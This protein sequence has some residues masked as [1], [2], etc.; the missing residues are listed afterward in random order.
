MRR[1]ALFGTRLTTSIDVVNDATVRL[2]A[3]SR[4]LEN[5]RGTRASPPASEIR[6]SVR[7]S[8]RSVV[9]TRTVREKNGWR[10]SVS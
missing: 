8:P 10:D 3:K 5:I 9:P 6:A 7:L 4:G 1:Y 2:L